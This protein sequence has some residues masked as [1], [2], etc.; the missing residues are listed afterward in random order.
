MNRRL[1]VLNDIIQDVEKDIKALE[2]VPCSGRVVATQFGNQA[3]MIQAL[4][5]IIKS[6]I[7]EKV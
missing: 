6:L 4:A 2:G 3:A 1:E 5:S 7:E